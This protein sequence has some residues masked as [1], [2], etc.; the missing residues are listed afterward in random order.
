MKPVLMIHEV[1]DWMLK[2]PLQ[3]YIL[4]F[5]DGL[6]SQY[7]HF[8]HYIRNIPTQ[9]IFFISSGIV[10]PEEHAQTS[11]FPSCV[12]AHHK[13]FN[14]NFEDYMKVSQIRELMADPWVVI[15]GHS[16]NHQRLMTIKS[17]PDR[18]AAMRRDTQDMVAWFNDVLRVQ[19]TTFCYPYN[20][21]IQKLYPA[22]LK[23]YGITDFYG[24]ERIAIETLF[25]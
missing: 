8:D 21:D 2:L 5:D 16:H 11:L 3:D 22:M 14:G 18:V 7:W 12:E 1:C 23:Q 17:L 6:F 10:C 20:D 9:K 19:L 15:G 4:T 24:K 13:A 25:K